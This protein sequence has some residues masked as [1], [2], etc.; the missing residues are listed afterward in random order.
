MTN[1]TDAQ[2]RVL[3]EVCE[4]GSMGVPDAHDIELRVL[5]V[6]RLLVWE[7]LTV[8]QGGG[9]RYA[10]TPKGQAALKAWEEENALD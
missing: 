10:L 1:L 9:I 7:S 4:R 5:A 8:E 6:L 3:R 2:A